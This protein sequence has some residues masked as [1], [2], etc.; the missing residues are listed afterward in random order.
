MCVNDNFFAFREHILSDYR[1]RLSGVIMR[2]KDHLENSKVQIGTK[3]TT[4]MCY[5]VTSLLRIQQLKTTSDLTNQLS[6]NV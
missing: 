3:L 5:L 4:Y 1:K 2:L 6:V